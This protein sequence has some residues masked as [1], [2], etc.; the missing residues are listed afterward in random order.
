MLQLFPE[1][2]FL[3][4]RIISIR[5]LL[6]AEFSPRITV[7]L[8]CTNTS[9]FQLVTVPS[10]PVSLDDSPMASQKHA[11]LWQ[12]FVVVMDA[13]RPPPDP[14]LPLLNVVLI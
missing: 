1:D 7:Y 2:T 11:R 10:L 12:A 9:S 5:T 8:L 14:P 13:H 4:S 6:A 3:H